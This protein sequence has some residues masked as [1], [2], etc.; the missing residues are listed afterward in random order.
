MVMVRFAESWA[1]CWLRAPKCTPGVD[2]LQLGNPKWSPENTHNCSR[3]VCADQAGGRVPCSELLRSES[4]EMNVKRLHEAGSED[5]SMLWEKSSTW[6]VARNEKVAFISSRLG[7]QMKLLINR[8]AHGRI[9]AVA[10][11][12]GRSTIYTKPCMDWHWGLT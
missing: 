2:K 7:L 8:Q 3:W 6:K 4:D 1:A 11:T 10:G 12:A 5:V 9:R